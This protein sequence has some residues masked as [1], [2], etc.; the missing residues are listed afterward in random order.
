[1]KRK[2]NP[3]RSDE[4]TVSYREMEDEM[5]Q[6]TFSKAVK[7]L[8]AERLIT[9][10]QKGGLYRKRNFY[11]LSEDWRFPRIDLPSLT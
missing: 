1:M 7:E 6:K 4:I 9:V 8:I 3:A 10:T 11:R 5:T 2:Y